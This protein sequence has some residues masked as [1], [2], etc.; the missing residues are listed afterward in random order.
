SPIYK[1]VLDLTSSSLSFYTKDQVLFDSMKI[2]PKSARRIIKEKIDVFSLYQ[3]YNAWRLAQVDSISKQLASYQIA[4]T[5]NDGFIQALLAKNQGNPQL[6]W[7]SVLQ[8]QKTYL[9]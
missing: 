3:N 2:L 1:A 7:F 4:Q 5:K 6:L 9:T 8:N